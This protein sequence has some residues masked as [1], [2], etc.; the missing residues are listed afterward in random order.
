MSL[1]MF[2]SQHTNKYMAYENKII[3]MEELFNANP[4]TWHELN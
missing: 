4:S 2:F 3:V 1:P